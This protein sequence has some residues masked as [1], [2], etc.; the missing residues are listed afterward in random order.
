VPFVNR[1]AYILVFFLY[2]FEISDK[3][4]YLY[5]LI[6]VN[7]YLRLLDNLLLDVIGHIILV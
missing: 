1:I 7:C 3:R 2:F 5:P 6:L 4:S